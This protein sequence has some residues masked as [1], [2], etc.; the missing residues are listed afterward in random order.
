M[1]FSSPAPENYSR[2]VVFRT[3]FANFR[4]SPPRGGRLA[5]PPRSSH[6]AVFV[7]AHAFEGVLQFRL[8]DLDSS[9]GALGSSHVPLAPF[10]DTLGQGFGLLLRCPRG[11][12]LVWV[13]GEGTCA[14]ADYPGQKRLGRSRCPC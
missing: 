14:R 13:W 5:R 10:F 3:Y 9:H 1:A 4:P 12:G 6:P 7:H 2:P 11:Q 8:R